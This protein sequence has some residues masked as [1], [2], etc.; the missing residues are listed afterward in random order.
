MK[1]P[2]DIDSLHLRLKVAFKLLFGHDQVGNVA[3][4]NLHVNDGRAS[5]CTNCGIN[6]RRID[7]KRLC[8][9]PLS[10]TIA[11]YGEYCPRIALWTFTAGHRLLRRLAQAPRV[12]GRCRT[13][14]PLLRYCILCQ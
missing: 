14:S 9:Q 6:M 7:C 5:S 1:L 4:R 8:R 12:A 13:A 11:S 3:R 10:L 2:R